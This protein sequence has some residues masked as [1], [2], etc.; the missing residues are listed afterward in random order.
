MVDSLRDRIAAILLEDWP[1]P[2]FSSGK[3]LAQVDALADAVIAAVGL[4]AEWG[5]VDDNGDGVL[6]DSPEELGLGVARLSR[7]FVTDWERVD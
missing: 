7:R 4:R 3:Q 6:A 1:A 2:V 5:D